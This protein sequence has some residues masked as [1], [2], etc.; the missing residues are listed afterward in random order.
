MPKLACEITINIDSTKAEE[1]LNL[2]KDFVTLVETAEDLRSH[3]EL[4]QYHRWLRARRSKA[5]APSSSA[6]NS[7][8]DEAFE[9][10]HRIRFRKIIDQ[11]VAV[12][13][14]LEEQRELEFRELGGHM[15]SERYFTISRMVSPLQSVIDALLGIWFKS[16]V[17]VEATAPDPVEDI[18]VEDAEPSLEFDIARQAARQAF[19][20]TMVVEAW[21]RRT[22]RS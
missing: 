5:G 10:E 4:V 12:R 1:V 18:P 8:E 14:S 16:P 3:I 9:D 13:E 2:T 6:A 7:A 11:I 17:P 15:N 20:L 22:S 19:N 21:R